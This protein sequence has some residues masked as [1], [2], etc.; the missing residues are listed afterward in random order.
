[1]LNTT[2]KERHKVSETLNYSK[3]N[4]LENKPLNTVHGSKVYKY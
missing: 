2:L 3:L 4:L 1:M